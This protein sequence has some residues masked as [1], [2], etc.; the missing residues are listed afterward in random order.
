[1]EFSRVLKPRGVVALIWNLEDMDVA[2][3]AANRKA[4]EA[5][6]QGTPQFRLGL[7]RKMYQVPAIRFFPSQEEREVTWTLPTTVD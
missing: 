4:Y 7:W 6:E 2:W 5:Y 1:T 3:V